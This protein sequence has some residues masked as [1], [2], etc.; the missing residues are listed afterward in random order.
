M[1]D[2]A[3]S[4]R[5]PTSHAA[6]TPPRAEPLPSPASPRYGPVDRYGRPRTQVDSGPSVLPAAS[7][8]SPVATVP[9][10]WPPPPL[11]G[12]P[13]VLGGAAAAWYPG[14]PPLD[15]G[16][17]PPRGPAGTWPA[18]R[19][20][21]HAAWG[22]RVAAALIDVTP[23]WVA[24]AFLVAGYLPTY[25]GFFRGD[26]AVPPRF[27]L[28]LVGTLLYLAAFA[29]W[30]YSSYFRA[31]RTGQSYGK[32][33]MKIWLVSQASGRPIGPLNAFTRDLLHVLDRLGCVGYLWP[34][35]DDE[36]Q[37]LAD[38]IAQTIVVRTPVAPLGEVERRQ[39]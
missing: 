19:R 30:V 14:A 1:S 3:G 22:R 36:R 35:W 4:P 26:L 21:D 13:P 28:V 7:P 12:P 15:W 17:V 2:R 16:P 24:V 20:D 5:T 33:I 8:A 25:A 11:I 29:L 27:W 6:D 32:R 23:L 37:T 10:E 38:K 34:L 9:R 31:G 39:G 18:P